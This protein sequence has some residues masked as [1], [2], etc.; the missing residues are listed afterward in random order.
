VNHT[1]VAEHT[2]CLL[3]AMQKN[4]VETAN[5]TRQ[6]KWLRITGHELWRK[7]IGLIGMGRIGQEMARRAHGFDMEI[8][9]FGNFWPEDI[10]AQYGVIRHD[11][12]ESLFSAVDIISPHTKLNQDT[13]HLINRE[14]LAL[15]PEGAYVVNTGRGE[16]TD[17]TAILE[18]LDSGRL[19]GY[20]TDVME[21]EPPPPDHPLLSHP[22]VLVTAHIGSR[23]FES[24]PRQAKMSLDNLLNFL[25]GSGPIACANGVIPSDE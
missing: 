20:A 5:A 9:G 15:M 4:L 12:L 14:R 24:V 18:A 19:A 25:A 11:T 6:G 7:R 13:Y 10:A 21:E 17:S 16:L 1:T 23:T 8:H 2:F 22:K 3:L